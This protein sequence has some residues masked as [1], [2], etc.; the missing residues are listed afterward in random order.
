MPGKTVPPNEE[1]QTTHALVPNHVGEQA[2]LNF[3]E[4]VE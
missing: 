3:D 1:P 2:A 4:G